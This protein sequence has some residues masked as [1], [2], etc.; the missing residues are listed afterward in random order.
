M[1]MRI[2]SVEAVEEYILCIEFDDNTLVHYDMSEDIETLPGYEELRLISGLW[3]QVKLDESRTCVYWNE[4][5]DLPSD[6]LYEYGN[7]ID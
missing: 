3:S 7:K 6:V 1:I 4:Y 5:I 2:K